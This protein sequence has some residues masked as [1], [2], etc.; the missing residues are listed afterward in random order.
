HGRRPGRAGATAGERGSVDGVAGVDGGSARFGAIPVTAV[1]VTAG[2]GV[3]GG[4]PAGHVVLRDV[5]VRTTRF[6]GVRAA[7]VL[8]RVDRHVVGK[9]LV[10]GHP[11]VE[12]GDAVLLGGALGA[13][14]ADL[15]QHL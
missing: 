4:D 12:V 6:G 15:L 11:T 2:R 14:L 10:G 3:R 13:L 8:G 5:D 1:A 7:D 9:L